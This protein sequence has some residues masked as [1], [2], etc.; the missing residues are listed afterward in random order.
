MPLPVF[1]VP[2]LWQGTVAGASGS[3]LNG[4]QRLPRAFPASRW[5]QGIPYW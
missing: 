3:Y 1:L 5:E 2:C 4:S